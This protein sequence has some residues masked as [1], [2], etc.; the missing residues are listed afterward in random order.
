MGRRQ[1]TWGQIMQICQTHNI[2]IFRGKGS[3]KKLKGP[4]PSGETGIMVIGHKCCTRPGDTVYPSYVKTFQR[5]F[6][7]KN[8]TGSWRVVRQSLSLCTLNR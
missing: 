8:S 4:T 6:G 5:R 3:E 7:I 1:I 2:E